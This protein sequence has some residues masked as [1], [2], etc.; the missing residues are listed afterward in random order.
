MSKKPGKAVAGYTEEK[1]YRCLENLQRSFM[2][3]CLVY[4]GYEQNE[5]GRVFDNL[6]RENYV[7]HFVKSGKGIFR[8]SDND[9]ELGAG[10]AFFI[11]PGVHCAYKSDD[12]DPWVYTWVGFAGMKAETYVRNAGF[13]LE[14][15]VGH[16]AQSEEIYALVNQILDCRNMDFSSELRRDAYLMLIFSILIRNYESVSFAEG[17]NRHGDDPDYVVKA[18][19]F[20]EHHYERNIRIGELAAFLGVSRSHFSATFK[21]CVGCSIQEY[22]VSLRMSKAAGL[23]RDTAMPVYAVANAVGYSDQLA[24]SKIFKQKFDVSPLAYRRNE[25][26]LLILKQKGDFKDSF[27]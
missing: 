8:I 16:I 11:P 14:K 13:S 5:P 6:P 22:I 15:P 21:K 19:D 27:L 7:L 17:I 24:F 9:Y 26:N 25:Q 12:L 4:C 1:D 18:L 20:T 3:I 2:D 23:L 10:D